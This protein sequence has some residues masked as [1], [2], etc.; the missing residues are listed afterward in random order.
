MASLDTTE[1][2]ETFDLLTHPHRRYTLHYLSTESEEVSIATLASEIAEWGEAKR[3]T[4]QNND[5][6]GIEIALRHTHLP[7]IADAGIITYGP[8]KD[9]I[10]LKGLNGLGQFLTDTAPIDGFTRVPADD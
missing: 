6:E 8:D 4:N 9:S 2:N 1:L 3:A 7:K 10:K 5:P